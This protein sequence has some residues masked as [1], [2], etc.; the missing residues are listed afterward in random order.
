VGARAD[1][2][3]RRAVYEYRDDRTGQVVLRPYPPPPRVLTRAP[4]RPRV[5]SGRVVHTPSRARRRTATRGSPDDEPHEPGPARRR[6]LALHLHPRA[7]LAHE[8]E[9]HFARAFAAASS[10]DWHRQYGWR[11]HDTPRLWEGAAPG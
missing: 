4:A 11:L 2:A 5:R 6:H 10:D 7:A 3:S 8:L 1:L 9:R